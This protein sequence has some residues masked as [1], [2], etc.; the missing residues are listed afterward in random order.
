MSH[1][2]TIE[3]PQAN[4]QVSQTR[5]G[6]RSRAWGNVSTSR[7]Y[8]FLYGKGGTRLPSWVTASWARWASGRWD[9]ARSPVSGR[10]ASDQIPC[11]RLSF[12]GW[13]QLGAPRWRCSPCALGAQGVLSVSEHRAGSHDLF[14]IICTALSSLSKTC[15]RCFVI[16]K[17][18]QWFAELEIRSNPHDETA[19]M[20][21]PLP[22]SGQ[23]KIWLC[24]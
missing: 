13:G 7:Q 24:I 8:D 9:R 1:V 19:K 6:V 17:S 23:L 18:V 16:Q 11:S 14:L 2:V 21:F 3:E 20:T 4:L 15:S 5:C 10:W 12:V 22:F